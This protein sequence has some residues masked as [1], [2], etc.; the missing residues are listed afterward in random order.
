MARISYCCLIRVIFDKLVNEHL[1]QLVLADQE[2]ET[3]LE[4]N[5]SFIIIQ[6]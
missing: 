6:I 1:I 4:H 5:E 2:K 3:I